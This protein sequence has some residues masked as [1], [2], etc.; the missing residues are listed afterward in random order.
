MSP[1]STKTSFFIDFLR[2]KFLGLIFRNSRSDIV[3]KYFTVAWIFSL[4][5]F[6]NLV[7]FNKK[8]TWKNRDVEKDLLKAFEKSV[9]IFTAGWHFR[10]PELLEKHRDELIRKYS[11]KPIYYEN[12]DFYKKVIALKTEENVLIGVHIRRGDYKKWK[13]GQ[14]YF[15]DDVYQKYMSDFSQKLF[16]KTQKNQIFIIF[17]NDL[18]SF[19]ENEKLLISKEIW[20]IDHFIMSLCDY[21]IGTHSTFSLWANF[22][23]KNTFFCIQDNSGNIDN[24]ITDFRENDFAHAFSEAEAK[25]MCEA[26]G[27]VSN[28]W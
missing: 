25:E 15:E 14:Y 22:M 6:V 9:I 28:S 27:R 10:V 16:E 11:L 24:T 3:R 19:V 18:V 21:L 20:Y 12:N 8:K 17:S 26:Q 4:T 1:C 7:F 5:G 2:I 13:N 23:G